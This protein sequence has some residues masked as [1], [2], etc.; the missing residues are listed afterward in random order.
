VPPT[1]VTTLAAALKAL[2][3][4]ADHLPEP[5]LRWALAHWDT[6]RP[7][8]TQTL[9]RCARD[10]E[11]ASDP[12]MITSYFALHLMAE[13]R[14]TSVFPLLRALVKSPEG[15]AAIFGGAGAMSLTRVMISLFDG[16][17]HAL[18]AIAA[19]PDMDPF[20]SI[21]AFETLAYATASGTIEREATHGWLAGLPAAYEAANAETASWEGWALAV[22]SLG[23]DDLMPKVR[24]VFTATDETDDD[25]HESGIEDIE[26]IFQMAREEPD[27][28]AVFARDAIGPVDDAIAAL[29]RNEAA[30]LAAEDE[31]DG[32]QYA[33]GDEDF[34]PAPTVNQFRD[35]GRN[36]PCPCGSGKKFKKCCLT[37]ET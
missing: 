34:A 12:D 36:D 5:A 26:M 19:A 33:D 10:P 21:S 7:A 27:P 18:R 8:L 2:G 25:G 30:M 20:A 1:E 14:E 16:D 28:L 22:A 6:A 3:S 37:A 24:E 15:A 9:A 29:K 4:A 13:K 32:G 17:T 23:F 11:G 35:V 31:E